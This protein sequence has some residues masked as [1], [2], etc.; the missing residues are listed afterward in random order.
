MDDNK[1]KL[2]WH[3]MFLFLI[4]LLTGL[5]EQKFVNPRMGLAAHLEGVMNGTFLI[6]LGAVWAEVRL[7]AR[8]KIA[9]FWIA[10]YGSYVNWLA[11]AL[12]ASFGSAALSPITGAGHSA[13]P[14]QEALVTGLFITVGLAMIGSSVMV[15]WGLRRSAAATQM[16]IG[17]AQSGA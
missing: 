17:K 2:I 12:A 1:R 13:Q 14:W 10:L 4:G 5:I 8:P 16:D 9:A 11:T 7:S 15:L 6:A 3:G